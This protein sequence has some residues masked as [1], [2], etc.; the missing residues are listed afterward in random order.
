MLL[1]GGHGTDPRRLQCWAKSPRKRKLGCQ[2]RPRVRPTPG[3]RHCSCG[4]TWHTCTL[5]F[6]LLCFPRG[7]CCCR[8]FENN[9]TWSFDLQAGGTL[10]TDEKRMSILAHPMTVEGCQNHG[11]QAYMAQW[12]FL[13]TWVIHVPTAFRAKSLTKTLLNL[14]TPKDL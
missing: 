7:P 4:A 3:A 2:P 9:D 10:G 11:E 1:F 13:K 6:C 14:A 5:A 8:G 12:A